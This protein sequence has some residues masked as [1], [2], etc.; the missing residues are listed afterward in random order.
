MLPPRRCWQ[1]GSHVI[2]TTQDRA[3]RS[4]QRPWTVGGVQR[5]DA[6]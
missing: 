3:C 4:V 6:G 2:G 1:P 5:E